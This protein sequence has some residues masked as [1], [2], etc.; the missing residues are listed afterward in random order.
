MNTVCTKHP[1]GSVVRYTPYTHADTDPG[2]Y[3]RGV[4]VLIADTVASG[5]LNQMGP[6]AGYIIHY[7]K[8]D[9]LTQTGAA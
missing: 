1:V 6:L 5:S 4:H 9:P 7:H 2:I 8:S 3:Q